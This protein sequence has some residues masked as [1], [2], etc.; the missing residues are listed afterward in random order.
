MFRKKQLLQEKLSQVNEMNLYHGTEDTVVDAICF[1]NFDWRLC[2]KNA[3]LFGQGSYFSNSAAYSHDYT[4]CN[5]S[6]IRYIFV[7]SV[8]VGRYA[9][10]STFT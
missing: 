5:N 7:A 2:G 9:K 1:Q 3:T 10:V 8:L 6:N 4:S